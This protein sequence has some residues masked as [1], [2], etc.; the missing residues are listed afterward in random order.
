MLRGGGAA[1]DPGWLAYERGDYVA[2]RS[3]YDTA[4]RGGDRLAQYNL[5]MMLVRGEG[6]PATPLRVSSG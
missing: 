2:A 4:A 3:L 5:A 1:A 6:G